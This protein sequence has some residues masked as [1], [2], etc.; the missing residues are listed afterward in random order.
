MLREMLH[1]T[2]DSRVKWDIIKAILRSSGALE[3]RPELAAVPVVVPTL[4]V[5]IHPQPGKV[6]DNVVEGTVKEV[7]DGS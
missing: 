6:M 5:H 7:S 3:E 2:R 1:N 4:Q